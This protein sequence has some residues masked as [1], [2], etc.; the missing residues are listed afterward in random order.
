MRKKRPLNS[1]SSF[2]L[3]FICVA[4]QTASYWC[5]WFL[6]SGSEARHGCS[7]S[8]I[9]WQADLE[10]S[11]WPGWRPHESRPQCRWPEG[12][13]SSQRSIAQHQTT[14]MPQ[15][16]VLLDHLRATGRLQATLTL[17]NSWN[18]NRVVGKL[19]LIPEYSEV[20]SMC[21]LCHDTNR[22]STQRAC[23]V[24]TITVVTMRDG[25][26]QCVTAR[27]GDL[28]QRSKCRNTCGVQMSFRKEVPSIWIMKSPP[29]TWWGLF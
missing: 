11:S 14:V 29:S 8:Y 15:G 17:S 2:Q 9:H 24:A 19:G 13:L 16:E 12:G 26:G 4:H 27:R 21:V 28:L 20:Y 3:S 6:P 18:V 1:F 7:R 10:P 5:F 25:E 22:T 23:I